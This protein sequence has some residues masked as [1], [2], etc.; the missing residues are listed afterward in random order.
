MWK[1]YLMVCYCIRP[2]KSE[3]SDVMLVE[4][5][6][7]QSIYIMEIDKCYDKGLIYC[8]VDCLGLRKCLEEENVNNDD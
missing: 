6:H 2:S 5:S 1:S 7:G 4:A 8:F 3:F